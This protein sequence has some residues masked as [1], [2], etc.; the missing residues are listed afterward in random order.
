M[1]VYRMKEAGVDYWSTTGTLRL[2][3]VLLEDHANGMVAGSRVVTSPVLRVNAYA[4]VTVVTT[5]NS[6]YLVE[7]ESALEVAKQVEALKHLRQKKD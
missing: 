4:G 3:G 6:T 2:K 7:D 1:G 5:A